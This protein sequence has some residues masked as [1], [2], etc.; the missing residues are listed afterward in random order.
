MPDPAPDR[1]D[2]PNDQLMIQALTRVSRETMVTPVSIN[3][4]TAL[5]A[6]PT[7]YQPERFEAAPAPKESKL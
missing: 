1:F 3:E 4:P 7:P 5:V 2:N 6:V